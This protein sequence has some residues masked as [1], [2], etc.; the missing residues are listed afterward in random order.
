MS[1]YLPVAKAAEAAPPAYEDC[2]AMDRTTSSGS[3]REDEPL[4][5]DEEQ[6]H[7]GASGD[8]MERTDSRERNH[9]NVPESEYFETRYQERCREKYREVSTKDLLNMAAPKPED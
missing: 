4:V 6:G 5:G 1:W 9:M 8:A 2:V 7:Y 3:G